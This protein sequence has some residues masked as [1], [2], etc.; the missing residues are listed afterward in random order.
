M[1]WERIRGHDAEIRAFADAWRRGRLGHAYF[2][3]GPPGVG[4]RLLATELAKALLCENV[5]DSLRACDRCPSCTLVEADMHPD[6]F[7][8]RRPEDSHDLPIEVL[9]QLCADLALK[10][11]R[12]GR[13]VA[14]VDDADELN[15]ASANCFLKTLEEPPPRS[16]L[17]LIGTGV[18]RQLPTI[19]SRC[20]VVRF[21]PLP[22][23]LV[24]EL[25]AGQGVDDPDRRAQLVRLAAG[26]PGQ[27]L[28]LADPALWEFRKRFLAALTTPRPDTVALA[29]QLTDFVEEVGK[30]SAAQR[31]RAGLVLRLVVSF[32][33]QALAASVG[34][35]AVG[36]PADRS[37]AAAFAQRLGPE[38]LLEL[39][40][41][42]L[43][44][45]QQI[46]RKVQL[47]LVLE[48]LADA[49]RE[50]PTIASGPVGQSGSGRR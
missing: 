23:E 13:K 47:V 26:S 4:K 35:E 17:I 10:P 41:R 36:D 30:E 8:A 46:D 11:A 50:A 45:D 32:L 42:C 27:A 9:R 21:A 18:E 25:L 48:A 38:R 49:F 16:V 40:D 6:C 3:V 24:D 28:E 39:L 12:G 20:Q 29:G 2:F 34:G 44:A 19:V 5:T 43:E 14:V 7:Q 31:G 1:S 37:A 22:A 15:E 33:E